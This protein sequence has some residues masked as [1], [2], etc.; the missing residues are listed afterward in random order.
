[1]KRRWPN[2]RHWQRLVSTCRETHGSRWRTAAARLVQRDRS[3]LRAFVDRDMNPV[4]IKK[5]DALLINHLH[6]HISELRRRIDHIDNAARAVMRATNEIS[7]AH[8]MRGKPDPVSEG[9]QRKFFSD[10]LAKM[11]EDT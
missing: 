7:T 4:D 1:M 8:M 10:W 3:D 6:D 9:E 2:T 5:L 11:L